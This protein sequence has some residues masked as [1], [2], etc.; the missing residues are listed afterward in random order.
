MADEPCLHP[1]WRYADKDGIEWME[2]NVEA[3]PDDVGHRFCIVCGEQWFRNDENPE[4]HQ[5]Y[6]TQKDLD[7]AKERAREYDW[8][9]GEDENH[10]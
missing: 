10:E 4:W 6:W 3:I 5:E 7:E 9:F 1:E 2:E 8:F